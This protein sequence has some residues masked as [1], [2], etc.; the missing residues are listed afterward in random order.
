MKTDIQ[1]MALGVFL[2]SFSFSGPFIYAQSL[3]EV[4]R[5]VGQA[6]DHG[7]V[8]AQQ[9]S[10]V[11]VHLKLHNEAA[12]GEAVEGLYDPASPNYHH[13]M[14]ESDFAKYAP[15]SD[16][17][18]AVKG[19][20][21]SR[22]LSIVSVDQNGFSVRA[23]GTAVNL[24]RAFQTQLHLL[25]YQGRSIT[26]NVTPAKLTGAA[27]D[28]IAGITGL[29]SYSLKP[30]FKRPLDV[31]TG[32][33]LPG[34]SQ[35]AGS[36]LVNLAAA[37]TNQCFGS[38]SSEYLTTAGATLPVGLYSGN[39]YLPGT[40]LQCGWTPDQIQ[41]H[42][43]LYSAYVNGITGAGQTIAIL[44]GPTNSDYTTDL[45]NFSV[46][47][48]L[49]AITRA[50]YQ[51]IFP[52]GVPTPF[53]D[54]Q[55]DATPETQIDIEWSHAIAPKAKIDLFI[56]PT[57]DWEEFEYAI[58]YIVNHKLAKVISV[59]Y[60]LP[61]A[62][63]SP[64]ILRGFERTLKIAAAAGVAVQFSSGDVGDQ[65]LGSPGAG[66]DLYPGAS[67]Y[68][69]SIG[70]TSIGIPGPNG[71]V[72]VGWGNNATILSTTQDGLLDPP[73]ATGLAGGSGG[74][75]SSL[76]AKPSWQSKLMG[77]G[78]E[79]PDISAL[80]DPYTGAITFV[81]GQVI[82]SAGTS[83]AAPIF[84]SL[85]LLADQAAGESLGQAAPMLPKL[86]GAIRDVV[87]LGSSSNVTGAIIDSSGT[88]SYS[89]AALVPPLFSTTDFYSTLWD[90]SGDGSGAFID[91]TFG[92]DSSLKV[93]KGWDDVTGYGVPKGYAFI[94]MAAS[95]K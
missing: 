21:R 54:R 9:E 75:E 38:P 88:T 59:S 74:G 72:D 64:A 66:G 58:Q 61:E 62:L 94:K 67:E 35:K 85:W 25:E 91:L 63:F 89:A 36:A 1:K 86:L 12:F 6:V 14:T 3:V 93:T 92:T 71:P 33:P 23:H 42:Y 69:T 2:C 32:K 68:V 76:I 29:T 39:T 17:V 22:G 28:L 78:R 80:G 48:G 20:L 19:E 31:R 70:G 7:S 34:I 47:T 51:V 60:G 43:G 87:P 27:G 13:W 81:A 44:D 16:E 79:Q 84:S 65:G 8:P 10:N 26:A 40:T 24:E 49:P 30:Q 53:A 90:Q 57:D 73:F 15:S 4:P 55:Y 41:D 50:N 45:T 18:E 52:D 11:T 82:V 5:L 83:L 77:T 56:L 37:Y 95:L 46:A